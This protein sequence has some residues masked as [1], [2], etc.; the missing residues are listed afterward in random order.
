[1]ERMWMIPI[2]MEDSLMAPR[3]YMLRLSLQLL[4][5]SSMLTSARVLWTWAGR[6]LPLGFC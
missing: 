5:P 2:L 4:L 3:H 1:M 6:Q